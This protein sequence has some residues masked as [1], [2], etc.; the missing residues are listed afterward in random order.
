MKDLLRKNESLLADFVD[1]ERM[2]EAISI[3]DTDASQIP[4]TLYTLAT[5][6]AWLEREHTRNEKTGST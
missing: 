2:R 5:L 3:L 6:A 1:P 4:F